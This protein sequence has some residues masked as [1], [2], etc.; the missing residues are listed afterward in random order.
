MTKYLC[1]AHRTCT[2]TSVAA[3]ASL[4]VWMLCACFLLSLCACFLLS[5]MLAKKAGQRLLLMLAYAR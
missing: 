4:R 2:P 3:R 1:N 5:L